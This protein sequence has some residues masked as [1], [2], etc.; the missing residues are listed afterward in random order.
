[1]DITAPDFGFI[2]PETF[3]DIAGEEAYQE[4]LRRPR[5]VCEYDDKELL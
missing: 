5:M 1:M 4:L 3:K 2:H